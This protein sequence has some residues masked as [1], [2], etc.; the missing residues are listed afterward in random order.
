MT[1][2][3]TGGPVDRAA[4]QEAVR[5]LL[6][7][8]G[9]D[10]DLALL[11]GLDGITISG[12]VVDVDASMMTGRAGL[13][14]GGDMVP[15]DR[16]VT[17]AVG[18]GKQA[19]RHIDAWL[20]G[21]TYAPS[22]KKPLA[23]FDNL[24]TWYY[25]D[26][27]QLVRPQLEGARRMGTFDEVVQ[28]LDAESTLFEARRCLSCGNCFGC[29]SCFGVCPDNAVR[30]VGDPGPG[31]YEFD[32]DFCKG[33]GLCVAECPSGAIQMRA[34][35]RRLEVGVSSGELGWV[36]VRATSA[37]SGRVDAT[38]QVQNDSSAHVLA[39]QSGR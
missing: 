1:G 7:A 22:Q 25:S 15:S 12:G 31:G 37:A 11:D 17:V 18:H 36:E 32:Y 13:F 34:E 10:A 21:T 19:A 5:A 26:A 23:A 14:A 24:T 20:R 3:A 29:D 27:P 2:S 6:V 8:L 4:A 30:K 33:C 9:Q 35:T 16:T 28:G 38:L 39:S